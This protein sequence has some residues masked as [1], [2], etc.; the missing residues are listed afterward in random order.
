MIL[1]AF[2]S[3]GSLSLIAAPTAWMGVT[4]YMSQV[5]T[6]QRDLAARAG[7]LADA[8]ARHLADLDAMTGEARTDTR[9][10]KFRA[11]GAWETA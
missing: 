11:M 1:A 7:L 10:A 8:L 3:L 9:Y 5:W 4:A 6:A 2:A